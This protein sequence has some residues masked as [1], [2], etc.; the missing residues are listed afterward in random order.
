[1]ADGLKVLITGATGRIGR[2][3]M[4]ELDGDFAVT[5]TSRTRRDDPRISQLDYGDPAQVRA[6]FAGQDVVVHLHAKAANDGESLADYLQPNI[7]D[8]HTTYEAARLAGVR[9]VIFASSNHATGW[10][11][12]AGERADAE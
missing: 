5:G 3:L 6:A 7:V 2:T 8:V 4:E 11:E 9:R 1:M 12:I 10:T